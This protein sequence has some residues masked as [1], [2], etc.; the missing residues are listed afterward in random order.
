M[1]IL[2]NANQQN[3]LR[4]PHHAHKS[5]QRQR[6]CSQQG[7]GL[8]PGEWF[9]HHG[10]EGTMF[11]FVFCFGRGRR[12][13]EFGTT[14]EEDQVKAMADNKAPD[15]RPWLMQVFFPASGTNYDYLYGA[16]IVAA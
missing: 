7:P 14:E 10:C 16:I 5:H 6:Q 3:T 13:R 11:I 15:T 2:V 9:Y 4:L 1:L 12:E 8:P